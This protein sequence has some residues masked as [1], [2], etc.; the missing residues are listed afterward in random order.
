MGGYY[1][2]VYPTDSDHF[3]LGY[4]D[5]S[6]GPCADS[7]NPHGTPV[8]EYSRGDECEPI[9]PLTEPRSDIAVHVPENHIRLDLI[10]SVGL[11]PHKA[12][13]FTLERVR[14]RH[15]AVRVCYRM[16]PEGPW[17]AAAP[18]GPF[19]LPGLV[20]CWPSL[21]PGLWDLSDWTVGT[22]DVSFTGADG[23][24]W[25]LDDLRLS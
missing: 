21:A 18:V 5:S 14:N 23:A 24:G 4:V 10:D 19:D 9:D 16:P 3:H 1:T 22:V 7:E 11:P 13:P 17:V 25:A 6:I 2:R 15:A 20:Y 12:Q 8:G